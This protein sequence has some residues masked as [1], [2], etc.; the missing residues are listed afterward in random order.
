MPILSAQNITLRFG[1]PPL[2]DNVS[3]DIEAG[4]RKGRPYGAAEDVFV[5]D[6][7]CGQT[8]IL[9]VRNSQI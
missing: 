7:L 8:S 5:G 1:G 4:D 9:F 2:L 3:F 6:G